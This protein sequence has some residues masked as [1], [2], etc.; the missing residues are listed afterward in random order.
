MFSQVCVCSTFGGGVPPPPIQLMG[1]GGGTPILPDGEVPPS[2]PTGGTPFPGLDGGTPPLPGPGKGYSLMLGPGKGVPP[3]WTWEGVPPCPD[4]GPGRGGW[5]HQ[6][7]E[8]SVYLLRSWRYAS[9]VHAGGLSCSLD[10]HF[11][12]QKALA[13]K[14]TV[15]VRL[16]MYCNT[17][18]ISAQPF[19]KVLQMIRLSTCSVDLKGACHPTWCI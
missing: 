13:L 16:C 15:E 14:L 11:L 12:L 19:F 4:L 6:L 3:T 10:N 17:F 9:C 2:F 8:H 7:E 5:Y 18:F 1:G